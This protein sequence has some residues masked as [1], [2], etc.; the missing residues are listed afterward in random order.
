MILSGRGE[1]DNLVKK[2]VGRMNFELCGPDGDID[3]RSPSFEFQLIII[4]VSGKCM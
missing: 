3:L 2:W 4:I 1:L